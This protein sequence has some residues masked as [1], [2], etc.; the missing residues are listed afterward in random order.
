MRYYLVHGLC[1]LFLV[2]CNTLKWRKKYLGKQM[3]SFQLK[4]MKDNQFNISIPLNERLIEGSPR[5]LK[6][7]EI[8]KNV[9]LFEKGLAL[10]PD[11]ISNTSKRTDSFYF[12]KY[13]IKY[14]KDHKLVSKNIFF[15]EN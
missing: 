9:K 5:N 6:R 14:I 2:S 13:K 3:E 10:V 7:R 4:Y 15:I 1:F 8:K 12:N 11:S